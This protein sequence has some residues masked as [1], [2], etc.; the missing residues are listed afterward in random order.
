MIGLVNWRNAHVEIGLI[1]VVGEYK[2]I[3]CQLR[4]LQQNP[5]LLVLFKSPCRRLL[6]IW[7][8]T[9][10]NIIPFV[11][12]LATSGKSN[13]RFMRTWRQLTGALATEEGGQV[14]HAGVCYVNYSLF[15]TPLLHTT[16]ELRNQVVS[17]IVSHTSCI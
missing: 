9:L 17:V 14:P 6:D 2:K 7:G 16:K 15:S 5:K 4:T 3:A 11:L 1:P 12:L 8:I 13:A 10:I